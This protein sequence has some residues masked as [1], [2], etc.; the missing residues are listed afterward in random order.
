MTRSDF[1]KKETR[2]RALQDQLW[3]TLREY[4]PELEELVEGLKDDDSRLGK[5]NSMALGAVLGDLYFRKAMTR[6]DDP[7]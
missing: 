2:V 7:L 5:V 1:D 3:A 6:Y 4:I